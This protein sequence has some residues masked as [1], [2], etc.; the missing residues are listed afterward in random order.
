MVA[1]A[2]QT[3]K[4][5]ARAFVPAAPPRRGLTMGIGTIREARRIILIA[6]GAD[7]KQPVARALAP[8]PRTACPASA[9]QRHVRTHRPALGETSP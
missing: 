1:L 2:A 9:L 3:I 6:G 7:K 4:L 5:A 8:P